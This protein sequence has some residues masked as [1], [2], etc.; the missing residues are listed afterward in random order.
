MSLG[1]TVRGTLGRWETPAAEA[2]RSLFIDLDALAAE[3]GALSPTAA[4]VLEIGCG[5]GSVADRIC[6]LWPAAEYLGIDIAPQPG[7]R[8]TGPPDQA[9]FR[10]ASTAELRLSEPAGFD[11]VLV[12]DVLHHVPGD[13][14]RAA[15]L[16]DA[17]ALTTPGGLLL[18]KEWRRC[19]RPRHLLAYLADR[20][21]SGDA[22][23]RFM[24]D[25]EL[26]GLLAAAVPDFTIAATRSV[27]PGP[28]NVLHAL[29]RAPGPT[30][31]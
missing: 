13:E 5:D 1:Q 26:R 30:R 14:G 31:S 12:V 4:R 22:G 7:R 25:T 16:R 20:Y 11:V 18:V 19:A 27:R 15:L 23:V 9:Q 10:A 29:R 28:C 24:D 3:V 6:R 2:Y 17:A 8:F 21:V